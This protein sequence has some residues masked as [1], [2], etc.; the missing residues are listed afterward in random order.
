MEE[1]FQM[2]R[3]KGFTLVEIMIVVLIIGILLGVAVP[4]FMMARDRTRVRACLRNLTEID[5]AKSR[6]AMENSLPGTSTPTQAQLAPIFIK[7]MFPVCP[8]AGTYTVNMVDNE[9]SCSVHGAP[10]TLNP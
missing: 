6:W 5:N 8:T 7:G 9:P 10:S 2:T 4:Q 1:K 3:R